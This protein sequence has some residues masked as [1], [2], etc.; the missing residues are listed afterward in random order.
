[1]FVSQQSDVQVLMS[2]LD[3]FNKLSSAKINWAKSEA[4]LIGD[5]KRVLFSLPPGLVW[6][7]GGFK[8]L[9]VF[10]GDE[11]TV[12]KNWEGLLEKVKGRL[13]NGSG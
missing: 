10:L 2:V 13:E 11:V 3:D 5:W 1:M 8:Y 12:Q 7:R 4:L 9:G 6:K